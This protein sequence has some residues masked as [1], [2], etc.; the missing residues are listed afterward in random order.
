MSIDL[1]K[2]QKSECVAGHQPGNPTGQF[3]SR[4]EMVDFLEQTKD[5]ELVIVDES[6]IDFAGDPVPSFFRRPTAIEPFDCAQRQQALRRAG[7]RIG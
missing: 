1:G 6:F 4:E 7:L 3:F 2:A 5:L